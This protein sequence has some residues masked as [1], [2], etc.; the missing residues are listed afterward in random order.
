MKK[1]N[2]FMNVVKHEQAKL[3]GLE[4]DAVKSATLRGHKM[5]KMTNNHTIGKPATRS[6]A[7]CVVCG[8]DVE[9][10]TKPLP[11]EIDIGGEAVALNCTGGNFEIGKS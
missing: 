11:N 1:V 8:M 9:V 3:I 5:G 6:I 7:V 10:T 2:H 4:Y